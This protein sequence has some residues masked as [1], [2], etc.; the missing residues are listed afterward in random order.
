MRTLYQHLAPA[1]LAAGLTLAAAPPAAAQPEPKLQA[2]VREALLRVPAHV[3]DAFGTAVDGELLVTTFRPPGAGPFPLVVISHGRSSEKRADYKRQR[4]ESAARFF[5][6]K[7]FAVAVPLRL[8]YGE[9]AEAGDPEDSVSCNQPRFS[10]ALAAAATQILAVREALAREPD[11]D[12]SRTV[13]VGVS[14]G[15]I[16]T[17]AATSA[18]V[19]GQVAAINFAG[20]HGGDPDKHPGEPCQTEQLRRLFHAYGEGNA[21]VAPPTP[22]LWLYAENDRYFSPRNARRWAAAYADGGGAVDLRLLPP[23][24]EDGHRL[25]TT[26]N[27]MWQPLVDAFLAPLG[28]AQ[29]GQVARPVATQPLTPEAAAAGLN[30]AQTAGL[31]KFLAAKSPRAFAIGA[32]GHWGYAQGDDALSRALAFC[33]R[34][35]PP[36]TDGTGCHLHAVDDAVIRSTP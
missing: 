3:K 27:D 26:G 24:G 16:A 22:T 33:Q 13:L 21:R 35:L 28:F 30:P 1:L 5:V 36:A 6:R 17:I 4:Y 23:W 32:D 2:D 14:V 29:P 25:F 12:A 7:G 19:Q 18:H 8:G 11:I 15:G 10:P 31:Q 9:L 20:G 34:D